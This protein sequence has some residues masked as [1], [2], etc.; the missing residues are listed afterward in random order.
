MC[1]REQRDRVRPLRNKPAQSHHNPALRRSPEEGR[2][3]RFRRE[4]AGDRGGEATERSD[5]DR[6]SQGRG[7][8][9]RETQVCKICYKKFLCFL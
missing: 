5:R 8:S 2:A 3:G 7:T 9:S 1:R 6:R 4:S